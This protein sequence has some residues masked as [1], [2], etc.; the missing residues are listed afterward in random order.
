MD[1][2][3][4][5]EMRE[6][7][8]QTIEAFGLPARLLME[9]AGRG[10]AR[11][12]MRQYPDLS[13]A[14]VAVAAGR[15]NNG[16]DGSVI[17]RYLFQQGINVKLYLFSESARLQGDAAANFS[18][19]R[20]LG[21]P[22]TELPDEKAFEKYRPEMAQKQIW[23]DAILGTGLNSEVKGYLQSVIAFVNSLQRPVLA[24]DIPSG[25]HADTG[26]PCGICI[27]A[28]LTA[29]FAFAK[30]GQVQ[31]PGAAF[32]GDLHII[33]IG[34]PPYI[35]RSVDPRQSLLHPD[36]L[37]RIIAS[38][39]A[40]MHKGD[41][42][43][44]LVVA[45]APGKSGAAAM[46]AMSALR[47]GA[48]LVTLGAPQSLTPVLAPQALEAMTA[49]LRE[50][51]NGHLSDEAAD[52]VLELLEGKRCLALGPGIGTDPATCRLVQR[53]VQESPVPVIIDA[54]GL[55]NLAEEPGILINT[56]APVVLTP[57]P[58]EMGRLTGL[59]SR[60]VQADRIGCAREFAESYSAYVVLKGARTVIAQPDDQIY[61][62]PTGNPGMASGGM[63]D[64]LTGLI[65]G[66]I[67]Q[68]YPPDMAARIAV[69]LHGA[70][71]DEVCASLGP[72]GYLASDVM[73][74]LPK[75]IQHL[76]SGTNAT[77]E[78]RWQIPVQELP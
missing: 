51:S 10:A 58:G 12:L 68:G 27:K 18:L 37:R 71:A 46:T 21:V 54:D 47:A 36:Y 63:G 24:V 73:K 39:P 48:G 52:Q 76:K 43:H 72:F 70:A 2:V 66:F 45:G 19:L 1:L 50:T 8:R 62:N 60:A 44:V 23:V 65:S 29:T 57:H 35:A 11:V 6:M 25:L 56:H 28:A 15:G 64:V 9:N 33:D 78:A 32:T 4:A 42:G 61:I 22:V 55:N 67:A 17:A 74:Q 49:G 26:K 16:G 5:D 31:Q 53:L 7:D 77:D 40:D 38:R 41:T 30:T 75:T 3:T 14:A 69:F 20:T 13:S 34:I 59:T